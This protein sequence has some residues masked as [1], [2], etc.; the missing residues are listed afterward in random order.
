MEKIPKQELGDHTHRLGKGIHIKYPL[1]DTVPHN[2]YKGM[3]R[4]L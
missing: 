3:F 4:D 1:R 2:T